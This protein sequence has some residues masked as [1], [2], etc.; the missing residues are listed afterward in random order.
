MAVSWEEDEEGE[1][2]GLT[3]QS[4]AVC[5]GRKQW[6]NLT[7]DLLSCSISPSIWNLTWRAAECLLMPAVP[8]VKARLM[9]DA[10]LRD[11]LPSTPTKEPEMVVLS[12]LRYLRNK[13]KENMI[14]SRLT[15]SDSHSSPDR[16]LSADSCKS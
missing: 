6:T 8:V 13:S 15:R 3:S 5:W 2:E 4:P 1:E 16:F 9:E 10:L 12:P 7:L 14:S 11:W